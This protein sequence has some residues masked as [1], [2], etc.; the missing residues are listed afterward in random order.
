MDRD[1]GQSVGEA[2]TV[3]VEVP[4][5]RIDAHREGHWEQTG[6]TID[7][8]LAEYLASDAALQLMAKLGYPGIGRIDSIALPQR[9]AWTASRP[10]DFTYDGMNAWEARLMHVTP[11]T[12]SI[13][14]AA[15]TSADLDLPTA[16]FNERKLA[17][18]GPTGRASKS[19]IMSSSDAFFQANSIRC[20]FCKE[21]VQYE[22]FAS[23]RR[24]LSRCRAAKAIH[25][26]T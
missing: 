5:F 13:L 14:A 8:Q 3:M 2:K 17:A 12:E 25:L 15:D 7:G 23:K 11:V 16:H 9:P 20:G 6:G 24:R 10:P 26:V 19:E 4:G 22:C 18:T 21:T 1:S